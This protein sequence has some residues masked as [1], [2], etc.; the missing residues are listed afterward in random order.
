MFK[1]IFLHALAASVMAALAGFIYCRIYYFA[2]E[3]D[4]SKVANI[5][6]ISSFCVVFCMIAAFGNYLCRKYFKYYGEIIF[7]IILTVVS[8]A[9]VMLPISVTLPLDIKSPELFPG[10]AV[11][12]M[13]FPAMAWY[14]IN[15]VFEEQRKFR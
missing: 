13:F 10:L 5:E 11:P 7:N 2:T 12:M 3:I 9:L 14:T 4:F 1:R 6:S 8:F 15:P